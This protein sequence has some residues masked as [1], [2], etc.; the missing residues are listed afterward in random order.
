[1]AFGGS[2]LEAG[3]RWCGVNTDLTMF[4]VSASAKGTRRSCT[5]GE[6][7]VSAYFVEKVAVISGDG[8]LSA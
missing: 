7:L 4:L 8:S 2:G 3:M 1:M 6:C 5:C